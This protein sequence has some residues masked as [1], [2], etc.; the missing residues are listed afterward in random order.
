MKLSELEI[1]K[2][3][4]V[5]PSWT[6]SSRGARDINT[7]RERD[8]V[9]AT[10]ISKDKYEYEASHRKDSPS[11]FTKAQSGNRSVGVI[12]KATDNNGTDYYW[13]S[14]LADIVALYSDLEP[15]WAQRQS[16]E[17]KREEEERIKRQRAQEISQRAI[18]QVT[19][20]RNSI[21]ASCKDLLGDKCDVS[22]DTTGYYENTKAVVA[23]TI[24]DFERLLE[25][26]YE[27]RASVA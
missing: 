2:E 15:R 1:G 21:I 27:G 12:V 6:Y 7:V 13:T 17:Q 11:G 25:I 26:A 20:T 19:N 10:V 8:V 14:R 3:Y 5:V 24:D 9:K 18:N 22:V 16:E 23:I 4:A